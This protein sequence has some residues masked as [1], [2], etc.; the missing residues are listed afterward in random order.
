MTTPYRETK[1]KEPEPK[2]NLIRRIW[3]KLPSTQKR[4]DKLLQMLPLGM[5]SS[6]I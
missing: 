3:D 4:I 5:V 2:P 6:F 1:F